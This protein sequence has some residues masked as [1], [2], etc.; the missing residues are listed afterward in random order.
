MKKSYNHLIGIILG[1]LVWFGGI[2]VMVSMV[3]ALTNKVPDTVE[4]FLLVVL[5]FFIIG[6]IYYVFKYCNSI[7]FEG[8][9]LIITTVKG[10]KMLYSVRDIQDIGVLEHRNSGVLIGYSLV[11]TLGGQRNKVWNLA[12]YSE[13]TLKEII[14]H[15]PDEVDV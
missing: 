6:A 15:L 5:P 1:K 4:W 9:H 14:G 12:G 8:D 11:L 3:L 10:E 2:G 13:K 7:D